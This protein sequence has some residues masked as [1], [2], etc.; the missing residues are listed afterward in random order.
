MNHYQCG[1]EMLTHLNGGFEDFCVTKSWLIGML[2][3]FSSGESF[4]FRIRR[5]MK[6]RRK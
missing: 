3:I 5:E 1:P 2:I 4:G 6:E